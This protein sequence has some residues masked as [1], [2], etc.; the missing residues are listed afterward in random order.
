M[1]VLMLDLNLVGC[2]LR[3]VIQ[4]PGGTVIL[5]E[6]LTLVTSHIREYIPFCGQVILIRCFFL[7]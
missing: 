1:I 7:F 5:L 4:A 3:A 6:P 2:H